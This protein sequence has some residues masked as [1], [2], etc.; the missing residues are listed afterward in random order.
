M[1]PFTHEF[2]PFIFILYIAY[3]FRILSSSAMRYY[4]HHSF[5]LNL[6]FNFIKWHIY[7]FHFLWNIK[8]LSCC[9][10]N[11]QEFINVERF[12]TLFLFCVLPIFPKKC[13][14]SNQLPNRKIA[15]CQLAFFHFYKRKFLLCTLRADWMNEREKAIAQETE[16]FSERKGICFWIILNLICISDAS[17]TK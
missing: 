3:I 6:F 9:E 7:H 4:L 14:N 13:L 8:A 17:N 15:E 10:Y 2:P 12:L 11:L 1:I 16:E 5:I